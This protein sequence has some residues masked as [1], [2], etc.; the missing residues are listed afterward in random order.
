MSAF[1]VSKEH[2]DAMVHAG[3]KYGRRYTLRWRVGADPE[4]AGDYEA[5][6]VA[7]QTQTRELTRETADRVGAMLWN[8]NMRSVDHR[9]EQANDR[10][11]YRFTEYDKMQPVMALKLIDCY[12]YQSC[13]HDEWES[14]EAHAFCQALRKTLIHSLPGYDDAPWGL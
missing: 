12:E 10:E 8:E 1:I 5:Y 7:V 11:V 14:S 9:Y 6:S 3:L 2:I 4:W 13:E